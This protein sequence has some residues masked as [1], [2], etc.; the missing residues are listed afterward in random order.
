VQRSNGQ[1][2]SAAPQIEKVDIGS[3]GTFYSLKIGPFASQADGTK[4]CNALKRGG[5]DCSVV[6]PD[7]P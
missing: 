6:S 3:F 7:G 2:A 1:L 4:L 5:T